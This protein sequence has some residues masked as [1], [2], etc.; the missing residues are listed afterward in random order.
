MMNSANSKLLLIILL[1]CANIGIF[2]VTNDYR[3]RATVTPKPLRRPTTHKNIL[4]TI[5]PELEIYN[6]TIWY[7][8]VF[9]GNS[10]ADGIENSTDTV[11]LNITE[12]VYGNSLNESTRDRFI[13]NL[14]DSQLVTGNATVF[15]HVNKNNET[16]LHETLMNQMNDTIK[17]FDQY[18]S[19]SNETFF[20]FTNTTNELQF[21]SSTESDRQIFNLTR[22]NLT[23]DH[24]PEEPT[25]QIPINHCDEYKNASDRNYAFLNETPSGP[26]LVMVNND[27]TICLQIKLSIIIQFNLLRSSVTNKLWSAGFFASL[28]D[29]DAKVIGECDNNDEA[30]VQIEWDEYVM[31]WRFA[32]ALIK[33]SWYLSSLELLTSKCDWF[34]KYGFGDFQCWKFNYISDDLMLTPLGE[35]YISCKR[36]FVKLNSNDDSLNAYV[37]FLKDEFRAHAFMKNDMDFDLKTC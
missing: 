3:Q 25:T 13:S 36:S 6:D 21:V 29:S 16:D 14:T 22:S 17:Y 24:F 34:Y 28:P 15:L 18:G 32:K 9:T 20:D 2:N 35:S 23:I 10:G 37:F 30:H 8:K 33:N 11:E 4:S 31:T 7:D 5:I 19:F 1:S 27:S 12:N 26:L